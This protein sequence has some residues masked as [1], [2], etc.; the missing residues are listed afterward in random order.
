MNHRHTTHFL[1]AALVAAAA[2]M[3]GCD[4]ST[5]TSAQTQSGSDSSS[6]KVRAT[7]AL[8]FTD[9]GSGGCTAQGKIVN[10]GPSCVSN[11]HGVT[12]LFDADGK[13]IHGVRILAAEL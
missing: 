8:T 7:G 13:E 10:D 9:C 4:M 12:H 2:V 5:P 3:V 1:L 11:V 6:A